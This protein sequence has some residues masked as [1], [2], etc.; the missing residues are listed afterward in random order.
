MSG[1]GRQRFC[2]QV[3]PSPDPALKGRR[4]Y[5]R[6]GTLL[7]QDNRRVQG[8]E[9]SFPQVWKK[10]W[11]TKGFCYL[12]PENTVV[13]GVLAG[14]WTENVENYLGRRTGA[15]RDES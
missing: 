13:S 7:V 15:H 14:G 5:A 11:K 8:A 1:A 3:F 4:A 10:L 9:V 12:R 2:D 6:V